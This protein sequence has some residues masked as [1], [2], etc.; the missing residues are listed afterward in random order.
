MVKKGDKEEGQ[1]K[2]N[3]PGV[4]E[5]VELMLC[6]AMLFRLIHRFSISNYTVVRN[7]GTKECQIKGVVFLKLKIRKMI[8]Y[9]RTWACTDGD[10]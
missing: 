2:I 4:A 8:G 3:L 7:T 9:N 10:K 5:K 1:P 6:A